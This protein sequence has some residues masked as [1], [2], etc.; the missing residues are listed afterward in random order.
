M[1]SPPKS[2]LATKVWFAALLENSGLDSGYALETAL[3]PACIKKLP[4]GT[5]SRSGR[6]YKY[7]RGISTPSARTQTQVEKKY[8]GTSAWLYAPL[9]KLISPD[10]LGIEEIAAIISRA[11][12][13]LAKHVATSSRPFSSPRTIDSLWRQ[14]DLQAL[15][16][17][18]A[19]TQLGEKTENLAVY[20]E[21]SWAALHVA[22]LLMINTPLKA[23]QPELTS[24]L[25]D[26]YFI[27]LSQIPSPM[28]SHYSLAYVTN[29]FIKMRDEARNRSLFTSL[30]DERRFAF[31]LSTEFS[32]YTLHTLKVDNV[33]RRYE[34]QHGAKLKR[35]GIR[36]NF[37]QRFSYALISAHRPGA[38]REHAIQE[39]KDQG[40][41]LVNLRLPR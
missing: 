11:R 24:I 36:L 35:T 7:S 18:L 12:P 37:I 9:W 30:K 16:A 13:H 10:R 23:I 21:A 20:V 14:G 31:W 17:L 29:V 41:Q 34:Q 33:V 40:K 2:S 26:L 15:E 6:W 22:A 25:W 5:K 28:P 19:I 4:D 8:P 27:N 1:H 32:S 39:M 38:E 3:S